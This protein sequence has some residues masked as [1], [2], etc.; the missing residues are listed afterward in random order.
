MKDKITFRPNNNTVRNNDHN[1]IQP[2]AQQYC[3]KNYL[4]ETQPQQYHEIFKMK[5][6]ITFSPNNTVRYNDQC[7]IT[8]NPNNTVRKT[9]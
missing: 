3:E 9:I 7:K 1:K 6:K 5:D 4:K 8:Y 2:M